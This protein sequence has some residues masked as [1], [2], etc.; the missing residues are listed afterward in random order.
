MVLTPEIE[1]AF[2]SMGED[3]FLAHEDFVSRV[4]IEL[5]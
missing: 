3:V 1:V 2:F 5:G 4:V